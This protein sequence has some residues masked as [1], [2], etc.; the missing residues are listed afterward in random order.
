MRRTST[1]LWSS[2][3]MVFALCATPAFGQDQTGAATPPDPTVEAQ[4][5]PADP[6]AGSP[7]TD[8][9]VQTAAG[10][11]QSAGDDDA[12]VVTGLRRSLQSSQNIKRNSE[13]IVD[14]IVAEDIGKL[15]DT[16]VSDTAA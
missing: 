2:S 13:Q 15:P 6:E 3:A 4:E 11:D 8:D 10:A 7:Q 14:A 9:A 16:T 12:I 1:L 5:Q